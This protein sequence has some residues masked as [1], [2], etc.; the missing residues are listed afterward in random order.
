MRIS[1]LTLEYPLLLFLDPAT[2]LKSQ[3]VNPFQIPIGD[4]HFRI[5]EQQLQQT[6]NSLGG[7]LNIPPAE[8]AAQMNPPLDGS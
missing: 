5:R 2:G 8:R 3:S 7:G 6:V 1:E 4:T